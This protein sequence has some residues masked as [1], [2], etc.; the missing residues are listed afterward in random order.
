MTRAEA[1][2]IIQS[3]QESQE[4]LNDQSANLEEIMDI[5]EPV[6]ANTL[7]YNNESE[8][9]MKKNMGEMMCG[10]QWAFINLLPEGMS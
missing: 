9:E 10:D 4:F 6:F 7:A 1:E 2:D 3:L 5:I 8:K